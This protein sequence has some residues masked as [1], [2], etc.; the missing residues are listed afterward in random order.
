[1]PPFRPSLHFNPPNLCLD[2]QPITTP[3]THIKTINLLRYHTF[4]TDS[5]HLRKKPLSLSYYVIRIAE[6]APS[7]FLQNLLQ[8]ALSDFLTTK[9]SSTK[10]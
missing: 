7:T 10:L 1:M 4:K 3:T 5:L 8:H 6:P 9:L 2:L